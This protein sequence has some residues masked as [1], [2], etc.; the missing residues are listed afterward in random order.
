MCQKKKSARSPSPSS[1]NKAFPAGDVT[2]PENAW[3][4]DFDLKAFRADIHE[5]GKKL[6][7]QQGDADVK[8]LDKVSED[9]PDQ[10]M[11]GLK[12]RGLPVVVK[13]AAAIASVGFPAVPF[14]CLLTR[15]LCGC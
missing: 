12:T 8:H 11:L 14:L 5:L 3:L 13:F 2:A 7:E 6:E 9:L 15:C 10:M 1:E 4:K